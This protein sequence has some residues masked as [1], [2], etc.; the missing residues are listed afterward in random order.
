MTPLSITPNIENAPWD[1]LDP[2]QLTEIRLERIGL[3][4]GGTGS[5]QPAVMLLMRDANGKPVI[6]Q[7]T[8]ALF[9]AASR[10]LLASPL[11]SEW[12]QR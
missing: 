4:P 6:T 9:E 10:A 1:D 3:M 7:T 11:G 8:F 12:S 2:T 5:G